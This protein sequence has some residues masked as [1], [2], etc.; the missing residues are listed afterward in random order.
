MPQDLAL[1]TAAAGANAGVDAMVVVASPVGGA[2]IIADTLGPAG[3][4]GVPKVIRDAG[5]GGHSVVL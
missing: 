2:L 5:A 4:V 3:H 1:S